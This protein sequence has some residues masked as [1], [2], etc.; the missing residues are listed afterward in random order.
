MLN[1]EKNWY[2][3]E[4]VD[5]FDSPA[6][7]VYPSRV[8]E[9]IRLIL[10]SIKPANLRPH[11]KTN[12]IAEVC[13]LMADAGISKFKSATIAESEMLAM[14]GAPDVLL[15]YQ[16]T[17]PKIK[18]LINLVR[19]YPGTKFSCLVD[20]TDS[21]QAISEWFQKAGLV[22][23]VYIDLNVGMNRTGIL[24]EQAMGL[25]KYLLS[26]P[27]IQV[28]GLHAYDGH[29]K[30]PDFARRTENCQRAFAPVITLKQEL[31]KFAG[32][33]ITLVAGGSP[34]CFIHGAAGDRECSP[35]TFVF[36]DMGNARQLP[37]QPFQWAAILICRIISIPAPDMICV[38]L[39]HKSVAA[40]N[41]QPRIFFLN[42]PEAI[43]FAQSEEH[44]VLKVPDAGKFRNGEV[45]YGVPWHICPSVALYEKALVVENNR[46][47]RSWKVVAR[48]REI[49]V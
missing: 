12:K 47:T 13:N 32:R 5:D 30:D 3:A 19:K 4:N 46:I 28:L 40:E 18:R 6:L 8:K 44:L 21:A 7:L 34:T 25:F 10:E 16:P 2:T 31:E 39:G 27:A 35:G 42:E 20:Q 17:I 41:P 15:A 22:A 45:L 36:W 1:I 23:K 43:P 38:D 33:T 37:E 29:L 49:S 14:A 26:L 9:N 24:P 48:D 11:V